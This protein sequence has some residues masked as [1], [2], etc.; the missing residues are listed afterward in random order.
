MSEVRAFEWSYGAWMEVVIHQP[1]VYISRQDVMNVRTWSQL[2][3]CKRLRV[4]VAK[5]KIPEDDDQAQDK[6]KEWKSKVAAILDS[7]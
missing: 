7:D 1:R 5:L 4:D 6:F 2:S 3:R